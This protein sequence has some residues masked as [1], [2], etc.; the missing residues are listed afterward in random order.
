MDEII[1]QLLGYAR[2]MWKFRWPGLLVAWVVALLGVVLVFRIPDQYEAS[3]RIYVDTQSILKPL[4]SGLTVQPNIEQ[5]VAMLS[6]TLLSRPNMEKL[7]RMADLDLKVTDQSGRDELITRLGKDIEIRNTGRDNLYTLA[8]RD[9]NQDRAKRVVQSLTSIFVE[10]SMGASRKDADSARSFLDEQI[11]RYEAKMAESEAKLKEFKLRNIDTASP[12]GKD[13]TTRMVEANAQIEAARLELREAENGRDS[14]KQQLAA[15]SSGG[16]QGA[17]SAPMAEAS[18]PVSTPEIDS[19][20]DAQKRNMD[21]LL[22]RYTEQ[23]PD[24]V[25]TRR[26]LKD[27]E[28][29][30]AA[31]VAEQRRA[32]IAAA[33]NAGPATNSGSAVSQELSR[34]LAAAEVQVATLRTRVNE[35]TGRLTQA[36]ASLRTAPQLEAEAAQLNRDLEMN[37]KNYEDL[38]ARRQSAVMSGELDSAAGLV[39]FRLIDPPRVTPKPVSPNRLAML[40]LALAAGVAAGLALAFV[41]SQLRPVFYDP[42]EVR[43]KTGLPLLGVVSMR[44]DD[45][46]KRRERGSLMRFAGATLGLVGLFVVGLVVTAVMS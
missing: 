21:T 16:G 2:G 31:E 6:R 26:L 29:Q 41:L 32:A 11:R 13:A 23:H 3:A 37:R 15:E 19:R 25:A 24:V 7:V 44:V 38:V 46:V 39:D 1:K 20:I 27:L 30:K 10:S 8:L 4:M 45:L 42:T 22:Q 28:Q 17:A 18:I 35:F 43:N 9:S 14:I 36:R 33:A 12:D 34:M 5:Q 40:P